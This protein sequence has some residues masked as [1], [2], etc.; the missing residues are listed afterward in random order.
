L[1]ELADSVMRSRVF[2]SVELAEQNDTIAPDAN[3][4][5]Y[6]IWFQVRSL[7]PN[8]AGPWIGQWQMQHG[9]GPAMANISVD[10]GTPVGPPRLLSFLRSVRAAAGYGGPV[11]AGS[12]GTAGE[13]PA[14][15]GIVVDGQGHVL[16]NNHVIANCAAPR[17][18]GNDGNDDSAELVATDATNDLALLKIARHAPIWARFRGSEGLQPGEAVI[19]TGFP[20]AGLVSPEMAVNTGSLTALAGFRGDSRQLQFSAPIQPG[21]SGGPLLDNDGR[22]IGI[23]SAML[24]GVLLAAVTGALPQNVNFAIKTDTARAF[25]AENHVALDTSRGRTAS[26]AAAV[27]DLARRF[28]VKIACAR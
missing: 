16:T 4:A 19:V 8:N 13:R 11:V 7:R 28:T 18:V 10:P 6:L 26:G 27:G 5:D 2:A 23:A 22:V 15:T 24:N 21:N 1:H 9:A 14:G 25:L 3:G 12:V 17:V 20:L